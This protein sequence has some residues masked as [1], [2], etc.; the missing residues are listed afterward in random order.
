M[1]LG[2]WPRQEAWSS[3]F[4]IIKETN[5]LISGYL[6][7]LVIRVVGG[8]FLSLGFTG[9]VYSLRTRH[10]TPGAQSRDTFWA[11]FSP[12]VSPSTTS[13]LSLQILESDNLCVEGVA[14]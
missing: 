1:R 12:A 9:Q 11:I 7:G 14:F 8:D 5:K 10:L 4:G 6:G 2:V 3:V 13:S